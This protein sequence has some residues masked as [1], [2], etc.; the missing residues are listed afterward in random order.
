MSF[1]LEQKQKALQLYDETKSVTMVIVRLGYPT[2]QCLYRWLR[3]KRAYKVFKSTEEIHQYSRA[4]FT[5]IRGDKI[6]YSSS[7]L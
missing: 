5:S 4:S 1:S 3:E 6:K 2:R 7:L